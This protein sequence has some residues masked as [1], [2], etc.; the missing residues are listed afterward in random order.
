MSCISVVGCC[1]HPHVPGWRSPYYLQPGPLLLPVGEGSIR[2]KDEGL[3][4]LM[5]SF[6]HL[7]PSGP[8]FPSFSRPFFRA[9]APVLSVQEPLGHPWADFR[10]I[11]VELI[12]RCRKPYPSDRGYAQFVRAKLLAGWGLS[13]LNNRM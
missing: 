8:G 4:S 5:G 2:G 3:P 10:I 6:L 12:Q 9:I 11:L 7:L 13:Q 1:L